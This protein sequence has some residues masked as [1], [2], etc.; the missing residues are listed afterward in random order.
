M[1][2]DEY[3]KSVLERYFLPSGP[4]SPAELAANDLLD[5]IRQWAGHYLVA[6]EFVGSYAT[7]TRIRGG[8]DID[9]LVSL[10][11]RTPMDAPRLYEHCFT[12]LKQH[13]YNPRRQ[14]VSIG[15]Q[16][17]GLEIDIIPARQ[18]WGSSGNCTLCEVERKRPVRTNPQE[19][20]KYTLA[21]GRT[22]EIRAIKVWRDFHKLRFPSFYLGLAV[23]DALRQRPRD[24]LAGN[25]ELALKYL[26]DIFPGV[27]FRDPANSENRVS[28]DLLEHERLAIADAAK[29]SLAA[30]D[31]SQ[32]LR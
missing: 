13:G 7:N 31:W 18:E 8:T 23:I 4:E 17:H 20:V 9:I 1:P 26:R 32:V 5:P 27:P 19:H 14:N 15:L 2:V 22:L 10:G 29:K 25:V 12:W 16:H 21:A 30:S 24:L 6:T 28:D 3:L 11:P